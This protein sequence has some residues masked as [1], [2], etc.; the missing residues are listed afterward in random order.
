VLSHGK[1]VFS[2]PLSTGRVS[3]G[4]GG[5]GA[6]PAAAAPAAAAAA[7]T[8]AASPRLRLT[9]V[10]DWAYV[11]SANTSNAAWGSAIS[12]AGGAGTRA[13]NFEGGVLF[14]PVVR[15]DVVESGAAAAA[16]GAGEASHGANG[17]AALAAALPEEL[18][19]V[20]ASFRRLPRVPPP[21]PIPIA[22]PAAP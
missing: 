10:R 9:L 18:R 5:G 4:G 11:G 17:E 6:T 14:P 19:R 13:D 21:L 16:G 22:V 15:L 12:I 8:A 1:G 7:P 3:G 2:V 20:L